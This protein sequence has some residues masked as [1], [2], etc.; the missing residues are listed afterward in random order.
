MAR[1]RGGS[2]EGGRR[3]WQVREEGVAS[4]GGGSGERVHSK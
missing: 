1:E 4:E 2:G 3:E